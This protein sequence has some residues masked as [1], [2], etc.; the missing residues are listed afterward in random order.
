MQIRDQRLERITNS[1]KI[2]TAMIV[3]ITGALANLAVVAFNGGQM[4]VITEEFIYESGMHKTYT[5]CE[6]VVLCPFSDIINIG[7]GYASVGDFLIL[8]GVL[9]G[10]YI[11]IKGYYKKIRNYFKM[12]KELRD[13]QND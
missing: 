2:I 7:I 4:P 8:L 10:F 1:I 11:M 12:R 3:V 5:T 13:L 9:A 6:N